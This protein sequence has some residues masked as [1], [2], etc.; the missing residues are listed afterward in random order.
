MVGPDISELGGISRVV[1]IWKEN[2]LFDKL[3]VTYI[4]SSAGQSSISKLSILLCGLF[5]F[6]S[7]VKE[8]RL[9][10]IHTAVDTSF[11][12]KSLFFCISILF[13]I[14][15]LLHIHPSAFINFIEQA[16]KIERKYILF[17]LHRVSYFVVLTDEMK[18]GMEAMLPD[19]VVFVL[20]NPVS[21]QEMSRGSELRAENKLLYL[22][23]YV[24]EKGVYEL[25]DAIGIIKNKDIKVGL[26]LYGV[27]G[28]TQLERYVKEKGLTDIIEV[29]GW[30]EH[31][32]AVSAL[33]A[34]TMLVLPSH[35]EGIPNV[36][37]E[38]MATKTPIVATS[39]GG[40]KEILRDGE[41]ALIAEVNNPVDLS[42][43][44]CQLLEDNDLRT[45]LAE[46]AYRDAIE[47]FDIRIIKKKFTRIIESVM[48]E[49]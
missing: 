48:I 4:S 8:N 42:K 33:Y 5:R 31:K 11:Y 28:R 9:T 7:L 18:N 19:K 45:Y 39:A 41:N 30:I 47:K 12:R 36:I 27:K 44:I 1:K 16:G 25:V 40:M 35:T 22:G 46:N 21:I 24:R 34:H 13:N 3:N 17:L 29:N 38:A 32:E 20:R 49:V 37:L 15:I 26:D 10:Y 6:I 23:W 2:G 43:K 14:P